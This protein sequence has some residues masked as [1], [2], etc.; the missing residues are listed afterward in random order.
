MS[1]DTGAN[2]AGQYTTASVSSTCCL[3]DVWPHYIKLVG[4]LAIPLIGSSYSKHPALQLGIHVPNL[5]VSCIAFRGR[6][7]HLLLDAIIEL[8]CCIILHTAI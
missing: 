2:Q 1:R 7:K 3:F 4:L 6:R 5:L 8:W